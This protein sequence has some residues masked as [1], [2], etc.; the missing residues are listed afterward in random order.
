MYTIAVNINFVPCYT[1]ILKN[2]QNTSHNIEPFDSVV[3][4]SF[5]DVVV[6]P[7]DAVVIESFDAVVAA[8]R[9]KVL[10]LPCGRLPFCFKST[11]TYKGAYLCCMGESH[12]KAGVDAP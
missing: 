9:T 7:Y 11:L 6:E 1:N 2:N 5:D 8:L 10:Y 3:I 4:E 12:A